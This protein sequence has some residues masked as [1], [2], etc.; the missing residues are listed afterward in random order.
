M[1]DAIVNS[2]G[3]AGV[4][5][6]AIAAIVLLA[7]GFLQRLKEKDVEFNHEI[8]E[9]EEAFRTFVNTRHTEFVD[10]H[11]Q[12]MTQLADNTRTMERV[13]AHLDK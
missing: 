8:R 13:I 11:K 7:R 2:L 6:V 5:V 4:G 12:T 1:E 3:E 10:I 9:R